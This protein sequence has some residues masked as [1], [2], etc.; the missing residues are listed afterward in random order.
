MPNLSYRTSNQG[1][2][3]SHITTSSF[4]NG[5]GHYLIPSWMTFE[6]D[7]KTQLDGAVGL[8]GN[9]NTTGSFAVGASGASW[10]LIQKSVISVNPGAVAA[11]DSISTTATIQT[12]PADALILSAQPASIWSGAYFDLSITPTVSAASTLRIGIANS[13]H[14][15]VTPD[16]MN[17]TIVWADPS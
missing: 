15:S 6:V 2:K 10:N 11:A 3:V 9:V 1:P 16:A 4:S 8:T 12:M 7:G 14:T 17:W 5:P 13:T